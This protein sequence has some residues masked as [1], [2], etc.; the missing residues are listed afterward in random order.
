[1]YRLIL[2]SL[3]SLC[4]ADNVDDSFSLDT[5][6]I[7]LRAVVGTKWYEFGVAVGIDNDV[8]DNFAS[9]CAPE[10]CIVEMLDFWLRNSSNKPTWRDVAY[11]LKSIK[12]EELAVKIED[13][14][15]TGEIYNNSYNYNTLQVRTLKKIYNNNNSNTIIIVWELQNLLRRQCF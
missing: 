9:H 7:Q 4:F 1:M 14:Y 6:L 5:L 3:L 8:L 12:L 11:T 2:S 15:S 13:F 10:E